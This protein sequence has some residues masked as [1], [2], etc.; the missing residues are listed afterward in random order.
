MAAS[1][2]SRNLLTGNYIYIDS[3]GHVHY[4]VID[5][6][7]IGFIAAAQ[8]WLTATKFENRELAHNVQELVAPYLQE[9]AAQLAVVAAHA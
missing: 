5:Q 9:R 6:R 4:V 2:F 1:S 3:E 8:T 7:V